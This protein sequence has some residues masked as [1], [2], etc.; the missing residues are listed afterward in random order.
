MKKNIL[1]SMGAVIA[2][3]VAVFILSYGTD[4]ILGSMGILPAGPLPLT[5]SDS[6]V[7]TVL[8]YRTVY[9]VIGCY[10]TARLAPDH[11]MRHAL[12]LGV[13]GLLGS[14]GGAL[15]GQ[16]LAPAWYSWMLVMLSLPCAWLEGRLYEL[17]IKRRQIPE[18][19]T[20][21]SPS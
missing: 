20:P 14:F 3:F 2:G 5:G 12:I 4:A 13:L 10:L 17:S 7:L 8:L 15:A 18:S 6:L 19:G 9:N 16:G 21:V 11:P 1:Q